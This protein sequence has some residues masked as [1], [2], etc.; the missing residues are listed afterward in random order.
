MALAGSWQVD[1]VS[2]WL[3]P[4][5]LLLLLHIFFHL[6]SP[7][8]KPLPVFVEGAAS[9]PLRTGSSS[10]EQRGMVVVTGGTGFLGSAVVRQLV[11]RGRSV[12]VIDRALPSTER[13]VDG[14]TYL[15]ADLAYN[16]FDTKEGGSGHTTQN[17][18]Y[19]CFK[20]ADAVVHVA[21]C[22]CLMDNPGLLHNA[23]IVATAN[24]IRCARLAGV[25]AL[26]FTSSGGAV[27]S[28]LLEDPQ[29]RVPCDIVLPKNFPFA[30]HYSRTKYVAERLALSANSKSFAG[31]ALRLPGLYG[32]GDS[33]IV[34]PLLSGQMTHV[35]CGGD[36][37]LIDFCYVENAAHAHCVALDGLLGSSSVAG[38]AFNVTNGEAETVPVVLMWNKLLQI[39]RPEARPLQPLPY[40]VAYL[41]ACITEA[42]DW[43][44]AGRVPYPQAAVWSLTRCSLGFA[45][46]PVT[47][48]LSSDLG[49]TPIFT[50]EQSFYDIRDKLRHQQ[51][52]E[53][54]ASRSASDASDGCSNANNA[55]KHARV[56]KRRASPSPSP[57][58]TTPTTSQLRAAGAPD[59]TLPPLSDKPVQRILDRLSGPKPTIPELLL[60]AS[61]LVLGVVIAAH[62]A[63]SGWSRAQW[64]CAIG[65]GLID[66]SAAVQCTT[67]QSKRWYHADGG[68]PQRLGLVI[69]AETAAQCIVVGFL[70]A[71]SSPLLYGAATGGW[72]TLCIAALIC[73]PLH[74]QR[75]LATQLFLCTVVALVLSRRAQLLPYTPG[76]EW[77]RASSATCSPLCLHSLGISWFGS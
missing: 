58:P 13:S 74:I 21:G 9:S 8:E 66:G 73:A 45:T 40:A 20:G 75:P 2:R 6:T 48:Q 56:R 54:K 57:P 50:T 37:C 61:G 51:G 26:V 36:E 70:Y 27:T 47:L 44:T 55:P 72:F 1:E 5:L 10:V 42:I 19:T 33:L 39:C 67:A 17:Y 15:I 18:I 11:Q 59:W 30:S 53:V 38:R 22:V 76:A 77:V 60:T 63:L 3:W 34:D 31:C 32:L 68:L 7:R 29:L 69:I 43:F 46:T 41:I 14:V 65:F 28:P 23:H 52:E 16:A 4:A 64:W 25:R 35:P 71:E 12:C 24:V 62:E 49:Y